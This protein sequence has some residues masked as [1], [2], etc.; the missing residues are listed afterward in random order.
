MN[1]LGTLAT[2]TE[3]FGMDQL[4]QSVFVAA[5]VGRLGC[6]KFG[7]G[8]TGDWGAGCDFKHNWNGAHNRVIIS[9]I[10]VKTAR[11]LVDSCF[12]HRTPPRRPEP[13]AFAKRCRVSDVLPGIHRVEEALGASLNRLVP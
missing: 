5:F 9:V 1:D 8:L 10:D 7:G 12:M 4:A 13:H 11:Y 3:N 2:R 6:R